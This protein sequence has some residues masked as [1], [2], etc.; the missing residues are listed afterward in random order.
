ML[1]SQRVRQGWCWLS[2]GH[3]EPQVHLAIPADSCSHLKERAKGEEITLSLQKFMGRCQEK[4]GWWAWPVG[5]RVG[6]DIV[7]PGNCFEFPAS[8]CV[9]GIVN[10]VIPEMLL[11]L[12]CLGL[13]VQKDSKR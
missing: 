9:M 5:V 4:V 3:T 2:W 13:F 6:A 8:G 7:M 12:V 11:N 1:G 10:P